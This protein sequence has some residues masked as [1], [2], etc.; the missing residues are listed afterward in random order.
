MVGEFVTEEELV[1]MEVSQMHAAKMGFLDPAFS[2][3]QV[4]SWWPL[5]LRTGVY[6]SCLMGESATV[7][8]SEI[9]VVCE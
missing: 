4:P 9:K 8:G 7:P 5:H 6:F 2:F 3:R 1:Q